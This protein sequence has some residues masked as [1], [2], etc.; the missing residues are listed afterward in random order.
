MTEVLA[1]WAAS[2]VV[3]AIAAPFATSL[4]RRFP[5][6][7][8]GL[9][10]A[11]GLVLV[12]YA[13]FI[14]RVA[15]VLPQGRGGVVA[16]IALAGLASIAAAAR[17]RRFARTVRRRMPEI[18]LAVAAFT[19]AFVAYVG[20]R[21]YTPDIAHTEQPMDFM[22][23]NA[24]I[25]SPHYPPHDPWL[26]GERASY[27]Y[28]GYVQAGVLTQ[29]AGVAPS[30]GYNLSLAWVFAASAAAAGSLAVALLR[31]WAR[32]RRGWW[33]A[34]AA[35]L[36]VAFLLFLGS[37]SGAFEW[38]AAHGRTDETLYRAFGVEWMIPCEPGQ[39]DDCYRGNISPRTHA[40]YPTEFWFWWRGSRII[41]DTITEFPF[42]SFL[43]GD[44]H[45]HLMAI[46]GVLL[47]LALAL[48]A[49]RGRGPLDWHAHR[50]APIAGLVLAVALGA[51]AF[52]NTWDLI[53]FAG[54]FAVTV[55]VRN[56]RA[57]P[58]PGA[59]VATA[60]YLGP[61][62]V[63]AAILYAPWYLDFSSQAAGLYAYTREGSRPEHVF[64][65]WGPLLAA[66]ALVAGWG[67]A[68]E[69]RAAVAAAPFTL[70]VAVLPLLAWVGLAAYRGTLG[71]GV[72]ARG[73]GGWVTLG[74]YALLVW[75]LATA[76]AA[77]TA[78][79]HAA[80]P[81]LGLAGLGVLLL[82]GA[83]LL[84]IRDVFFDGAPRLNTV[85]KLSYQAWILLSLAGAAGLVAIFRDVPRASHRAMLAAP[86]GVLVAV[87][88]AYAVTAIPNRTAG[89]E[90]DTAL[91]GLAYVRHDSPGEYALVQWAR[92]TL[93]P[94]TV[95]VEATGR[96]WRRG[97]DG[98]PQRTGERVD[99]SDAGRVSARTGLQTP[100]GWRGH[101]N[102][103]RGGS[104]G[105][106]AEFNRRQDLVDRV[107]TS[108]H[109]DDVLAALDELDAQYVVLGRTERSR[110]AANLLPSFETFLD[111]A[112]E[113]DDVRVYAV[114]VF[115]VIARP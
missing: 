27:Y 33:W 56:L 3:A 30:S 41:P 54:A 34:G 8:A 107:Y 90:Q 23:L 5:D 99:Y 51:L 72:D 109:P 31:W 94:S 61:I 97:D 115:E 52:T 102:Q 42:F 53:T 21:A 73:G 60:A 55:A 111:V 1:F 112:F 29:A 95:I 83:E 19:V 49:W 87:G 46:P 11:L 89:F 57:K 104:A 70:W 17:D 6:A 76:F 84:F 96:T 98:T 91:D 22:Y 44:L 15:G 108:E 37:L 75:A 93:D 66:G 10:F 26:A 36:A 88:L 106:Q 35:M 24:A 101:E 85:F 63:A 82:Y 69:R 58:M 43:L 71:D 100:I 68:R 92:N 47:A 62:A 110:Y 28:F 20:F 64:L 65:Q 50:R 25:T 86:A 12:S 81:A 32:T 39:D 38:A 2:L 7:G 79:R 40:W 13:Y 114:P 113:F 78:R 18:S 103:W 14:L 77:L 67:I 105:W 9:S 45:P 4:F 74:F 48:A 59:A 16:A 80:A